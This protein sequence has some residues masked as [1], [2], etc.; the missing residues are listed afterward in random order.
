MSKIN[1]LID[2]LQTG[3]LSRRE[4]MVKA[5]AL[6]LSLSAIGAVLSACGTE[7]GGAAATATTAPA[8]TATTAPAAAAT[9]APAAAATTAPAGGTPAASS[10]GSVFKEPPYEGKKNQEPIDTAK[11]KKP[12]PWTLAYSDASQ[13]NSWRVIVKASVEYQFDQYKQQGLFKG[14]LIYTD[15]NDSIPKQ[16]SDI[17]DILSKSPDALII[18]VTDISAICPA[19]DKADAAGVPT[20]ILERGM[21]CNTYTTYANV[22]NFRIGELQMEFVCQAL[23]GKG[24]I[25]AIAG[26]AG[27]G[28]SDDQVVSYKKVL[29]KYP[30]VKL[31]ALE[32]SGYSKTKGKQIME[33]ML[34]AYPQI[35]GVVVNSGLEFPGVFEAVQSAGRLDQIKAWTGDDN[36]GYMKLMV[37]YNLNGIITPVPTWSGI[38]AVDLAKKVL[39]GESVPRWYY[40][41]ASPITAANV[42]DYA[43]PDKPDEYWISKL[44][45][46]KQPY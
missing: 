7:S 24:N 18:A 35:D 23:N 13:T 32:Y 36:N 3:R 9:T 20:I 19:I 37:K 25:V 34:Q 29:A 44:P 14:D 15:A 46:D 1:S 45:P 26:I 33:N 21:T 11:W 8:A 4:F 22:D 5:A 42:K 27:G 38:D 31:L 6:G 12:G 41:E 2:D 16:L 40:V 43:R 39:G 28:S 10:T 30:D 17:E